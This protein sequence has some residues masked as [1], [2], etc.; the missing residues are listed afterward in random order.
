MAKG[1]RAYMF[2]LCSL[3]C[4]VDGG[5]SIFLKEKVYP[6]PRVSLPQGRLVQLKRTQRG[7]GEKS[8]GWGSVLLGGVSVL[9]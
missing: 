1:K 6:Y 5:R 4:P 8:L 3:F 9:S 7:I 2:P